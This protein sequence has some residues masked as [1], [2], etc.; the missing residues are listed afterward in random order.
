LGE[1]TR[2]TLNRKIK[3]ESVILSQKAPGPDVITEDKTKPV[4]YRVTTQSAHTGYTAE[5]YKI[6]YENGVEV[7]RTR[8]NKSTYMASPRYVTVGTIVGRGNRRN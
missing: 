3:F 1:E 2:D 7:S 5:L 4:S 8:V 6:I